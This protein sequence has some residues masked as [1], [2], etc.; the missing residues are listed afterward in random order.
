MSGLQDDWY[1]AG[2]DGEAI[3]PLSRLELAQRAARGAF[4]GGEIAAGQRRGGIAQRH[5]ER[6][7]DHALRP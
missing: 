2:P 3:G 5:A 1:V 7:I 6:G 4:G